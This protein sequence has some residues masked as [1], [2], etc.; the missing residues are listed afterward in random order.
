MSLPP[1]LEPSSPQSPSRADNAV[2]A[3]G[4]EARTPLVA[5][6]A[7]SILGF[8]SRRPLLGLIPALSIP[9]LLYVFRDP[10]RVA[11]LRPDL[12][13]SPADGKV[14]SVRAV[15]DG[16]WDQEMW[17]VVIFLSL[18]D[19]HVQRS[20]CAGQVVETRFVPGD[21]RPALWPSASERNERLHVYLQGPVPLTVT[22]VAGILARSIVSWVQPGQELASGER[23]G[24]I[25][26]GSQTHLRFP[27]RYRPLVRPGDHVAAAVTPITVIDELT[28]A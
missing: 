6:V 3:A 27:H 20:P 8:F 11:P 24:M 28:P 1:Q 2:G 22:Q 21:F 18:F 15:Q 4:R 10:P 23:I 9:A 5:L 16:Y 7:L 14:L 12:V 13:M 26:L 17:E 25:K 19:V